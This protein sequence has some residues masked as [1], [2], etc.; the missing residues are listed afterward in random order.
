[1]SGDT[2]PSPSVVENF[3]GVVQLLCDYSV[4]RGDDESTLMPPGPFLRFAA[5]L[6]AIVLSVQVHAD[7]ARTFVFGGSAGAN[8]AYRVV[9]Q[10]SSWQIEQDPV[11]LPVE[12]SDQVWRL[13]LP[14][15]LVVAPEL[16]V[17]RS[18]VLR[19]AAR[20]KEMMVG[21][22]VELVE[23]KGQRH[24]FSVRQCMGLRERG[25]DPDHEAVC[26]TPGKVN[27]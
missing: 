7:F 12:V 24:G 18:H 19:Y 3:V 8:L 4:V 6:A 15:V 9:V 13:A 14:P 23:F 25:I 22:A 11:H 10:A 27:Q 16:D 20:L 26:S 5:E 2:A 1:M 21:K 17:L